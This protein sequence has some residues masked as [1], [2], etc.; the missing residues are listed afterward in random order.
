MNRNFQI[1]KRKRPWLTTEKVPIL[2][3]IVLGLTKAKQLA[4]VEIDLQSGKLFKN[5]N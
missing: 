1:S 4:F 3:L 2:F 5:A